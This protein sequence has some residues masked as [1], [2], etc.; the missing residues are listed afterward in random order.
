MKLSEIH[1]EVVKA[2]EKIV[3]PMRPIDLSIDFEIDDFTTSNLKFIA[4]EAHEFI[5]WEEIAIFS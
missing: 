2:V 1:K 3:G 5:R 4:M